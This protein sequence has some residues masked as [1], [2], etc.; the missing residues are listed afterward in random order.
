MKVLSAL[1]QEFDAIDAAIQ[2]AIDV[3]ESR[4]MPDMAG[5]DKRVNALCSAIEKTDNETQQQCLLRLDD[6]L[7]RLDECANRLHAFRDASTA[8]TMSGH[9]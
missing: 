3:L 7:H 2:A 4:Q 1:I 5:L 6:L 9:G 8:G